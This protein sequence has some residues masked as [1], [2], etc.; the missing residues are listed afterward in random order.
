MR[1]VWLVAAAVVMQIAVAEAQAPVTLGQAP[2]QVVPPAPVVAGPQAAQTAP[3]AP[4]VPLGPVPPLGRSFAAPTG[5]LFNTVRP[6]RVADFESVLW[7][8]QQA[9]RTST[10]PVVRAQATGW[11]VYRAT[12]PGPN[13]TVMYVFLMDPVVP[14]ADYGLGRILADA[15]PDKVQEIWRLYQGSV[16][17]GGS[18]L[19]LMP[20]TPIQPPPSPPPVTAKPAPRTPPPAG[21]L[22]A[23]PAPR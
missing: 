4:V 2:P 12:E 1:L 13:A 8:L 3:A 10:D 15:Y 18:L 19:N 22:P 20:V 5:L 17:G 23:A 11:R 16:T 14:K 21:P 6:E 7:Y 9:L